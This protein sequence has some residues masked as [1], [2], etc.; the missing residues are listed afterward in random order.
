MYVVFVFWA[1]P[2]YVLHSSFI[3]VVVVV[4]DATIPQV[5]HLR[6]QGWSSSSRVRPFVGWACCPNNSNDQCRLHATFARRRLVKSVIQRVD[7]G[8]IVHMHKRQTIVELVPRSGAVSNGIL[9]SAAERS[10]C[11]WFS[12]MHDQNQTLSSNSL[13]RESRWSVRSGA[14]SW[15]NSN[16][17]WPQNVRIRKEM[18]R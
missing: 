7:V 13:R 15:W 18:C 14:Q 2:K 3:I 4:R 8:P 9:N 5:C 17:L 10:L 11:T 6:V 12:F 16:A 1:F